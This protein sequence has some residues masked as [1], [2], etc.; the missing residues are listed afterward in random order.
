MKQRNRIISLMLICI[1]CLLQA[2]VLTSC[3]NKKN[4]DATIPTLPNESDNNTTV[5]DGNNNENQTNKG[6]ESVLV[7]FITDDGIPIII[8]EAEKGVRFNAPMP[9]RRIGYVFNGWMGDYSNITQDTDII[10]SYTDVSSIVNAICAD[11]VYS[12]C[13][14]EFNVLI[15]IC[16]EVSFCGLDMD[17]K[18]DSDL[19]ELIEVTDIDNCVIQNSSNVGVINMNYVSAN[20]TDGEVTFMNLKFKSKTIIKAETNLQIDVNSMYL[21]DSDENLVKSTYQVIQNKIII[22]EVTNEK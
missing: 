11:T 20:N 6:V 19:L 16:G 15:G 7:R 5:T 14:S 2:L 9:P 10:A 13:G 17:I 3:G 21:L 12:L 22:E 18:Y 4:D 8:K 1:I